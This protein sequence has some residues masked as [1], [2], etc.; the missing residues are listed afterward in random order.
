VHGLK[1][2]F[3]ILREGWG[4]KHRQASQ[5]IAHLGAQGAQTG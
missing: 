4:V 5:T 1:R 2:L 3:Q